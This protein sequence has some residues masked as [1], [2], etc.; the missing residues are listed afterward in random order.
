MCCV[1]SVEL[2]HFPCFHT[3]T[4]TR[5]EVWENER[6]HLIKAHVFKILFYKYISKYR[7]CWC[8]YCRYVVNQGLS[9]ERPSLETL[10]FVFRIFAVHQHLYIYFENEKSAQLTRQINPRGCMLIYFFCSSLQ[11]CFLIALVCG[12]SHKL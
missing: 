5:V 3:V 2:K 1:G 4:K 8:I 9:S 12:S 10:D 11:V 7:K 6:L